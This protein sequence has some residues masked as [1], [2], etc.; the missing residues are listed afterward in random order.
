MRVMT[1]FLEFYEVLMKFVLFKLYNDAGL[2]YPPKLVESKDAAGAHLDALNVQS[3]AEKAAMDSIAEIN[4]TVKRGN[5][6][7][8]KTVAASE[9][10]IASLT[11]KLATL[12]K[13]GDGSEDEGD[14]DEESDDEDEGESDE[15]EDEGE[16]T[17]SGYL[18]FM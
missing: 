3:V 1:T 16:T 17:A 5:K 15:E 4:S 14:S 7:A 2:A 18:F 9:S 8:D 13:E 10:R 12:E 11:S 6:G